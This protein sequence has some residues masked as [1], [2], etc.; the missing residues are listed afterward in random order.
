MPSHFQ[1]QNKFNVKVE[2]EMFKRPSFVL[3]TSILSNIRLNVSVS[4]HQAI[5][6]KLGNL[7]IFQKPL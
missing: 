2:L 1:K 4:T 7:S 6:L 5:N 3:I